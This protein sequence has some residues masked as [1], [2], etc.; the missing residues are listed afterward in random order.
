MAIL[1]LEDG[2]V[3]RGTSFG[4]RGKTTGEVVFNTSMT[5]Y[6][7]ELSDP[8][9]YGQIL[10]ATYTQIGNVGTNIQDYESDKTYVGGL[11]VKEYIDYPSNFRSNET[12]DSFMVR[13]HIIG[14]GGIDTRMLTRMIRTKG[15][16]MGILSSFDESEEQL[17]NE[18]KL[19][20]PLVGR[21]IVTEITTQKP[22]DF[23]ES[24]WTIE[25]GYKKIGNSFAPAV[26]VYDFGIKKNILRSLVSAGL[27]PRVFPCTTPVQELL[28]DEYKGVVLSNGPGDPSALSYVIENTKEIIKSNKPILGICL[29]HQLLGLALGGEVVKL[30]FGHHG[31]NQSVINMKT[32]GIEITVQNHGFAVKP[33]SIQS[34]VNITHINLNDG[35]LEGFV[36]KDKP[37][38]SMQHH[39]E[40]SP[41]PTESGYIFEEFAKLI[42]ERNL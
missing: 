39:P 16:M 6:Q 28:K 14:M 4:Y 12:L 7:E 1:V 29:G 40:A 8:S 35:T 37:I 19:S 15:A 38:L 23:N 21:D 5:G 26:A 2:S 33:E 27:R 24:L 9:Y 3:F 42:H 32:R 30:K 41:G 25:H 22:Y 13:H 11:I 10:T 36:H 34:K 18:L 20:P 17:K 31:A